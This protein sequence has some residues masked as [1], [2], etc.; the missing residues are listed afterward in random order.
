MLFN[1]SAF[2][3][4]FLPATLIAVRLLARSGGKAALIGASLIFYGWWKH[5]QVALMA[6]TLAVIGASIVTNFTMAKSILGC[7]ERRKRLLLLWSGIAFNLTLLGYFK[8]TNFFVQNFSS[9][10]GIPAHRLDIVLPLGISFYS[11]QQIAFL[12][13]TYRGQI[14]DL[15]PRDYVVCVL[16]FPHLIA[17]PLIHYRDI[18]PQFAQRFRINGQTIWAGLPFFSVGLAKKVVIADSIATF[19]T[20]LFVHAESSPLEFFTAWMAALGYT[21]QLYFDFSGYSDMAVGLGLIFGIVLPQNFDSPYKSLSII[22]FWRRWHMTLSGFL[23]D[24]LYIPMGGGRVS[25]GR[26]YANLMIVM[27]L[28]GLWHGAGWTFVAW[29][30][31]TVSI[32]A[33]IVS[34]GTSE[35]GASLRVEAGQQALCAGW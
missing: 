4:C 28:G 21:V 13:D 29:G 35:R 27:L 15:R 30:L 3:F 26:R 1:S 20:P 12:V 6:E 25:T 22:E 9:L 19:V 31:C 34:G 17:G 24:Y 11:F 23:R 14:D 32:S 5:D 16:F 10:L 2:L 33:S 18:I 7:G 8:Y